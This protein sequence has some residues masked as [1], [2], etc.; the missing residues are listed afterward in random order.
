MIVM[1]K[2]CRIVG[3][4]LCLCLLVQPAI[5]EQ[6][7][8]FEKVL[9]LADLDPNLWPNIA[10]QDHSGSP[11]MDES[12]WQ[13]CQQLL[14]RLR[15]FPANQLEEWAAVQEAKP[16]RGSLVSVRGELVSFRKLDNS[17]QLSD[18]SAPEQMY[19][20]KYEV[21]SSH[22]FGYVLAPQVPSRWDDN[23]GA[24]EPVQFV[25]L[26]L[27][28]M[29]DSSDEPLLLTNRLEWYPNRDVPAGLLLLAQQGMDVSLLDEVRH[30]QPFVKASV[31]REGDAFYACLAALANVGPHKMAELASQRI[32]EVA[33]QWK[34][35]AARSRGELETLRQQ[36]KQAGQSENRRELEEAVTSTKRRLAIAAAVERQASRQVSSVAPLF[37]Q[38]EKVTGQLVRIEGLARRAV[39]TAAENLEAKEYYEL[40]VFTS[41][42]Q[43]RPVVCC[44]SRLPVGFPTGDEIRENVRVDGIFFKSWRYRTRK[45]LESDGQT[46]RQQQLYTPV[47]IGAEP[48]WLT[49]SSQYSSGWA[50]V[51]GV[52]VLLAFGIFWMQVLRSSRRTHREEYALDP[53]KLEQHQESDSTQPLP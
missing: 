45:N 23:T 36:L 25:G 11:V 30:R 39:R 20:C 15:Q 33:S 21:N 26:T 1:N 14:F 37:L 44:V 34:N 50:I 35:E 46:A 51:G 22:T 49:T 16:S 40:E 5:A 18:A 43:N 19:L 9:S 17:S 48:V 10:V 4:W 7:D 3:V 53:T 32:G 12:Q 47:V 38:P 42:S 13:L 6:A 27:G 8:D 31:S 2:A 52:G 24:G 41:D 29:A 28:H